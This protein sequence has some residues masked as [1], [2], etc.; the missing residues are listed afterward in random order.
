MTQYGFFYD[1]TRCV[2]CHSCTVACKGWNGIDA[3]PE[4]WLRVYEWEKGS[5]PNP[6]L[7]T[8]AYPCGHCKDPKCIDACPNKAIYKE[9]KYG[10]VLVDTEKCKGARACW[11]A[12]PYGTPQF[13]SEEPG[14]KMSKCTMCIDR[15]EQ[16]LKPICVMTCPM[17]AWDF[18]PLDELIAKYGDNRQLEGM[19]DPTETKPSIVFKPLPASKKQLIPYNV[20]EALTVFAK[21][22]GY[23][24]VLPPVFTSKTD[25]TDVP[26]GLVGRSKLIMKPKNLEEL[27]RVTKVD[28]A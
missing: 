15:L 8:L 6:R 16:G 14:T 24:N 28:D 18:G 1:Q 25:V 9:D 5:F 27:M 11:T 10:A 23:G 17:R 2:A 7:Y 4:K 13:E 26:E 12:C 20:D 22:E 21:R 19:P 3:G